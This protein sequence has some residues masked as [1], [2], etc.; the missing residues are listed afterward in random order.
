VRQLSSTE[1]KRLHRERRR[2]TNGEVALILHRVLSPLN[3]GSICRSA[4]AF[5]ADR[6]WC[7]AGTPPAGSAPTEKTGLGSAKYLDASVVPDTADAVAE[8]KRSGYLVVALELADTSVP[9]HEV[10]LPAK[11]C[12]LVGNEDQWLPA[13]VL[14]H[15][16]AIAYVPLL[17]RI[18]SLNVAASVSI[19]LYEARRREWSRSA[20]ESADGERSP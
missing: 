8:A 1:L 12:F 7:C 14:E 13:A 20:A 17:G 5:K 15:A 16:D 9:L 11:V 19:A 18:G 2:G 6:L 3:V 10:E 4:A